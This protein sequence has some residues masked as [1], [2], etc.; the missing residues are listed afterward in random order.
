MLLLGD[1]F[2]P[3]KVVMLLA[4]C[5]EWK[6]SKCTITKL[7]SVYDHIILVTRTAECLIVIDSPCFTLGN[8]DVH[9][10]DV[11]RCL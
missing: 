6:R 11:I 9:Y 4:G 8:A 1:S 10:K 2:G 5:F 7:Y 3:F